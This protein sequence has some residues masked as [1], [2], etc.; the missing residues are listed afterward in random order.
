MLGVT[1]FG[2][3]LTPVFYVMIRK[4][5]LKKHGLPPEKTDKHK[6]TGV[7]VEGQS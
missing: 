1:I 4:F 6:N 7:V 3:F 5:A 2:I